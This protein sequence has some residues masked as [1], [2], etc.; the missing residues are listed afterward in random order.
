MGAAMTMAAVMACL[1]MG[2]GAARGDESLQETV[3]A[4]TKGAWHVDGAEANHLMEFKQDG[5]FIQGT[6][7]TG[8]TF[9]KMDGF[10]GVWTV[11]G[12]GVTLSYWQWPTRHETYRL[13]IEPAGAQGVD[14][15]GNAVEMTRENAPAM[16]ADKPKGKRNQIGVAS[17][18]PAAP[19]PTPAF[20]PEMEARA[21]AAVKMYRNSIVFVTGSAGAG[22]GFIATDGTS[23]YL[24]TN[25]HVEAG[26]ADADFKT[27][28]GMSVKGG[29]A[30]MAVGEDLFR[31]QYPHGGTRFPLMKDVATDTS[32]GDEVVVLGNAEGAGVVNT[33][34]GKVVGIGPNLVEV[35]APFVPGNSGSPII[36]LKTGKVIGVAT[37]VRMEGFGMFFG[38]PED[39]RRFA[40]RLDS[41]KTWQPVDLPEFRK[42]AALMDELETR[43]TGIE[44]ALSNI[45]M[46]GSP[47]EAAD[48]RKA[49]AEWRQARKKKKNPK[50]RVAATRALLGTLH[51]ACKSDVAA[52]SGKITY[53]YFQQELA[54]IKMARDAMD[55]E[56]GP[57]V[58]GAGNN[59]FGGPG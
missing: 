33:L 55:K 19:A 30:S 54:Q 21:R 23:N 39:V 3:E 17:V 38:G 7:D 27:L 4:L 15:K 8:G 5:S 40:Y 44:E 25:V 45:E 32:I 2:A 31:M 52:A 49:I 46:N 42:Q 34:Y 48:L 53:D 11:S 58:N 1:A 47:V 41:V 57:T 28:D 14:E 22:S 20:P 29:A 51:D 26:L 12:S 18:E 24:I 56:V 10:G 6:V 16:A 59:R 9:T 13:P 35:D 50:E 37:Y 43:T 36:Q